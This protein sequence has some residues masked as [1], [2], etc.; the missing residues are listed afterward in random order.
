M[1]N[2]QF[3]YYDVYGQKARSNIFFPQLLPSGQSFDDPDIEIVMEDTDI[4]SESEKELYVDGRSYGKT[5]N[6]IWFVNQAGKF[7]IE[8]KDNVTRLYCARY[9]DIHE[10]IIRSF[11]LGNCI[12]I[13]LTQRN[14]IPLHGSSLI[15][16]GKTILVC[17]GSGAGKSTLTTELIN[18]GAVLMA[19]DISAITLEDGISYTCSGFPEQKLCRDAAINN[20]FDLDSLRYVNEDS[21]KF[22]LD[23]NDIFFYGRKKVD[24]LYIIRKNSSEDM[25]GFE[26]GIK[27]REITGVDKVNAV[28]DMLF[29]KQLYS[30]LWGFTPEEMMRC[31]ALAGQ[32]NVFELTRKKDM[33]T[34]A[35]LVRAIEESWNL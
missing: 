3:Y 14:F 12:A 18:R 23:R 9:C 33:D 29:L 21:D 27:A 34:I 11:F 35:Y 22:S 7:S 2:K 4:S 20:G 30:F 16:K 1:E 8:T 10:S 24:S 17:G 13:A 26:N 15:Y 6:G 32:I 19:D 5:E 28:T 31:V 25:T